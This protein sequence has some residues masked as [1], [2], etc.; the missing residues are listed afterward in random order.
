VGGRFTSLLLVLGSPSTLGGFVPPWLIPLEV[1]FLPAFRA[2][3]FVLPEHVPVE[4]FVS[5]PL[6]VEEFVMFFLIFLTG[7]PSYSVGFRD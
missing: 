4:V 7:R 3:S 1:R 2:W 6:W 5:Y